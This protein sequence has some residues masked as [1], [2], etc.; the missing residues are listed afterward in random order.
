MR[1]VSIWKRTDSI[2]D[3]NSGERRRLPFAERGVNEVGEKGKD[4]EG[5]PDAVEQCAH[6]VLKP[7]AKLK[8]KGSDASENQ[9][10]RRP[11]HSSQSFARVL[12][13]GRQFRRA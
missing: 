1:W 6:Q 5:L 12:E 4:E 8:K 7:S 9:P 3:K 11:E 13:K 10:D 2:F